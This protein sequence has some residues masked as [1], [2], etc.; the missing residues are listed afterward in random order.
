[1][2]SSDSK[3]IVVCDRD[4]ASDD[5]DSG[6]SST[7]SSAHEA[8]KLSSN[9]NASIHI[10]D[11]SIGGT[12]GDSNSLDEGWT[13]KKA[14]GLSNNSETG[15]SG[16]N[17]EDLGVLRRR[18]LVKRTPAV[19]YFA[20]SNPSDKEDDEGDSSGKEPHNSGLQRSSPVQGPQRLMSRQS[21]YIRVVVV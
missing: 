11:E 6:A 18:K 15:A 10:V 2:H 14:M 5:R 7:A 20:K 19:S 21:V 12:T 13:D 9:S 3:E 17:K 4:E 16:S 1:M 8:D